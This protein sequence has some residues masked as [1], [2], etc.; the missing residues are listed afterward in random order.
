LKPIL[1]AAAVA[2]VAAPVAGMEVEPA[3]VYVATTTVLGAAGGALVGAALGG[4]SRTGSASSVRPYLRW[5]ALGATFGTVLGYDLGRNLASQ[6]RERDDLP[7]PPTREAGACVGAI[8]GEGLG[9]AA[10]AAIMSASNSSM[11]RNSKEMWTGVSVGA[12]SGAATGFLMKPVHLLPPPA[13]RSRGRLAKIRASRTLEPLV[14]IT[15]EARELMRDAEPV[16]EKTPEPSPPQTRSQLQDL[17]VALLEP[18]QETGLKTPEP[19]GPLGGREILLAPPLPSREAAVQSRSVLLLGQVAGLVLGAA[20]GGSVGGNTGGFYERVALGGSIGVLAGW[21]A[22]SALG[23]SWKSPEP[24]TFN[25]ASDITAQGTR[26]SGTLAGG[27]IGAALGGV[28]GAVLQGSNDKFDRTAIAQ[29]ILVGDLLGL[30]AGSIL[31]PAG[32]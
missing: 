32:D 3:D 16:R 8:L 13:S 26:A 2:F 27:L 12:L 30:F 22:T 7:P 9:F 23:R 28:I 31:V 5:G 29:A 25:D 21:S 17:E 20:A 6:P 18:E 4:I 10:A 11:T 14:P 1:L 24:G 15:P 19:L